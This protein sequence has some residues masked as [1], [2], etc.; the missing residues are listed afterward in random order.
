MTYRRVGT[1]VDKRSPVC[2]DQDSRCWPWQ[3][4]LSR[5]GKMLRLITS[6]RDRAEG[7]PSSAISSRLGDEHSR[8]CWHICGNRKG[9]TSIYQE[10]ATSTEQG[11]H[12]PGFLRFDWWTSSK[13]EFWSSAGC[14]A[15]KRDTFDELQTVTK[16]SRKTLPP[17]EG[18]RRISF[19]V[20]RRN[21]AMSIHAQYKIWSCA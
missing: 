19:D 16:F 21:C 4:E 6:T 10:R 12:R 2:G 14:K 7:T 13:L 18:V 1:Y 5:S 3:G 15:Y 20:R 11:R 17:L 9:D 8:T